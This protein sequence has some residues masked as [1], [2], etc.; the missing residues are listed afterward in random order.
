[1]MELGVKYNTID[2]DRVLDTPII[3]KSEYYN[4]NKKKI[5]LL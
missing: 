4:V 3:F 2:V 5:N 1:M